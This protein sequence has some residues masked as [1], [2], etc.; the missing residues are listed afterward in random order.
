MDVEGLRVENRETTG[1]L[2]SLSLNLEGITTKVQG[3]A[4]AIDGLSQDMTEIRQDAAE[5]KISLSTIQN[6][7]VSQVVTETGYSFTKD[8][9]HISKSESN[10]ENL[11][12]ESGMYV[13]RDG[14]VILQ[15][16]DDGVKAVDVTVRNYLVVGEHARFEDYTSGTDSRRTACFWL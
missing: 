8:G 2:A 9:L 16:N 7:G 10:M 15:A 1:R 4:Q 11:L 12:D 5:V 6:E 3:Q 14:E 13:K